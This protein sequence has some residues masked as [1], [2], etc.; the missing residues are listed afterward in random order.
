MFR[1]KQSSQD[2][3]ECLSS[4]LFSKTAFRINQAAVQGSHVLCEHPHKD[5]QNQH[6]LNLHGT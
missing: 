6:V 4:S 2:L 5:V 3:S 1:I